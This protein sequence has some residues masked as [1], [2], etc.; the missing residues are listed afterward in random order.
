MPLP[1]EALYRSVLVV[2]HP[3]D[4]VLWFSSILD[5]V[6]KIVIVFDTAHGS[7]E[8]EAAFRNRIADHPLAGKITSLGLTRVRSH[9]RS[10]W[11]EPEATDYG[12]KLE[13]DAALDAAYGVQYQD[14]QAALRPYLE[15]AS[16]VFTHN[17]WGEYGHEDHVQLSKCVTALTDELGATVWYSNY[18]SGKSS[19]LMR[20]YVTGFRSDYLVNHIDS[21]RARVIADTYFRHGTWTLDPDYDWFPSECFIQG[22]LESSELATAGTLF[23]VNYL[24]VPFDPIPARVPGPGLPSRIRRRLRRVL[25]RNNKAPAHAATR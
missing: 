1:P 5:A 17:P 11:P 21:A 16:N 22:P 15:E 6:A 24:R 12:L 14:A 20:R 9:N 10:R 3:D 7:A 19:R 2:A 13:D 23:P 18:V 4:E 8:R 25:G